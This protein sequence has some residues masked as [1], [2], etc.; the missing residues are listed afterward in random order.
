MHDF[1]YGNLQY[2][3]KLIRD[4][5]SAEEYE[6]EWIIIAEDDPVFK[7]NVKKEDFKNIGRY[8]K[9]ADLVYME[10]HGRKCKDIDGVSVMADGWGAGLTAISR[11]GARKIISILPAY[12]EVDIAIAHHLTFSESR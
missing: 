8:P 3:G 12:D 5:V 7:Q 1:I 10:V 2:S 6:N 11:K 9:D 4:E